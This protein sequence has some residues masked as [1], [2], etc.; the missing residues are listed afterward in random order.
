MWGYASAA[1]QVEGGWD[2]DGKGESIWDYDAHNNVDWF[3]NGQ[4]G[5]IACDAYHKTDVDV[6][7]YQKSVL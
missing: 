3:Y 2:E 5:D 7:K 1:Y 4:T 6:G